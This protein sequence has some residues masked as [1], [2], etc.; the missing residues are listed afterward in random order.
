[1]AAFGLHD[2]PSVFGVVGEELCRGG[3]FPSRL[4]D[5]STR[6]HEDFR[7]SRVLLPNLRQG[8]SDGR[9]VPPLLVSEHQLIRAGF[10]PSP[11]AGWPP[12][13]GVELRPVLHIPFGLVKQAL[14]FAPRN[15]PTAGF[16]PIHRGGL[17]VIPEPQEIGRIVVF[18]AN[19]DDL[20]GDKR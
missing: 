12:A 11:N 16:H 19:G 7:R 6:R 5:F 9:L 14:G 3:D 13:A 17:D 2:H 15:V 20:P 1:M 8:L 10:V 4:V 18:A